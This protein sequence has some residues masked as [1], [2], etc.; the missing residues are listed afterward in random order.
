ME[1]SRGKL[2]DVH[3]RKTLVVESIWDQELQN[4]IT[5]QATVVFEEN[6]AKKLS[7]E[8]EAAKRFKSSLETNKAA[9]KHVEELHKTIVALN[10]QAT[11][12]AKKGKET[13]KSFNNLEEKLRNGTSKVN[14]GFLEVQKIREIVMQ[15]QEPIRFEGQREISE[16]EAHIAK[17]RECI[18]VMAK[19]D[20]QQFQTELAEQSRRDNEV[21]LL[22]THK[23]NEI[24]MFYS[25]KAHANNSLEEVLGALG[26]LE[27]LLSEH[28]RSNGTKSEQ[29]AELQHRKKDLGTA[30]GEVT[31][32]ENVF[33]DF[34]DLIAKPTFLHAEI[35]KETATLDESV[36]EIERVKEDNQKTGELIERTRL[37]SKEHWESMM[38]AFDELLKK[39]ENDALAIQANW[40]AGQLLYDKERC[41]SQLLIRL[42]DVEKNQHQHQLTNQDLDGD[43]DQDRSTLVE[44]QRE[45]QTLATDAYRNLP[46]SEKIRYDLKAIE[47]QTEKIGH[48]ISAFNEQIRA[49]E[50]QR[51]SIE[52]NIE[53]KQNECASKIDDKEKE[54]AALIAANN[55]KKQKIIMESEKHQVSIQTAEKDVQ[56]KLVEDDRKVPGGKSLAA[57]L[58][59]ANAFMK[60]GEKIVKINEE[61]AIMLSKPNNEQMPEQLASQKRNYAFDSSDDSDATIETE[62]GEMFDLSFNEPARSKKVAIG[63]IAPEIARESLFNKVEQTGLT[64]RTSKPKPQAKRKRYDSDSTMM[65]DD[66]SFQNSFFGSNV[67]RP[68]SIYPKAINKVTSSP[69]PERMRKPVTYAFHS[70]N[71]MSTTMNDDPEIFLNFDK[72]VTS[73]PKAIKRNSTLKGGNR[74]T[75]A[76]AV[77]KRGRAVTR[78]RGRGK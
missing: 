1:E 42:Q 12:I 58:E 38:Q 66:E 64:K 73:T 75:R 62:A 8:S 18:A 3:G 45:I 65:T 77:N 46:E 40:D 25:R 35:S 52:K 17:V 29:I 32:E 30:H 60:K 39:I 55:K 27:K 61:P 56:S 9:N 54:L 11:L 68:S 5:E 15:A 47:S 57:R 2:I 31:T 22:C 10:E 33:T 21:T 63:D 19:V 53:R 69:R 48:E 14:A 20:I 67:T 70:D 16:L 23:K 37:K 24:Q 44:C 6:N 13:E 26:G 4:Q 50:E 41:K 43:I 28:E 36:F 72:A 49:I 34:E 51:L 59:K 7:L 76:S 78:G 71:S 74:A